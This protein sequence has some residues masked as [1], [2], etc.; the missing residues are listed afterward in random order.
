[1]QRDVRHKLKVLATDTL[2]VTA[3]SAPEIVQGTEIDTQFLRAIDFAVVPDEAIGTDDIEFLI[4]ESDTS[5]GTFTAIDTDKYLKTGGDRTLVDAASDGSLLT[6]GCTGTKR[7]IKPVVS[8]TTVADDLTV[9]V[10]PI[11]VPE[12]VEYD[13]DSII[14]GTP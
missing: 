5:G 2:S 11:L 1:M 12:N 6:V 7:Y 14:S 10:V 4:Y 9:S 8:T 13:E 3:A